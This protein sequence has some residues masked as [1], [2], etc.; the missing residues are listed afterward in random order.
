VTIMLKLF[1]ALA[2]LVLT[3]AGVSAAPV[4]IL[5]LGDSLTARLEAAAMAAV[6]SPATRARL[7]QVGLEP[8]GSTGAELASFWDAQLA[9]WLPIVRASGATPD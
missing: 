1:T 8:A 3:A 4:T 5:A 7:V 9:L 2:L 6:R